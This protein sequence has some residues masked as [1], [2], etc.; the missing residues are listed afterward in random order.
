MPKPDQRP[1]RT[2]RT[3]TERLALTE[4]HPYHKPVAALDHHGAGLYQ[5]AY[6]PQ[7]PLCREE[8]DDCTRID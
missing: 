6:D 3:G 4:A 5:Q 2:W 8:T 1:W 7:C